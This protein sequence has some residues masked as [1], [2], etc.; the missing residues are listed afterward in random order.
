MGCALPLTG[1]LCSIKTAQIIIGNRLKII[2]GTDGMRCLR[3]TQRIIKD[4][5]QPS[6]S[7]FTLLPSGK[8]CIQCCTTR[9]QRLRDSSVHPLEC[10]INNSL[11]Y[12]NDLSYINSFIFFL[13][14][15]LRAYSATLHCKINLVLCTHLIKIF[16]I[17]NNLILLKKKCIDCRRAH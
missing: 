5:I 1:R 6:H 16:L 14:V 8:K 12:F 2:S 13:S 10:A 11:V 3:R 4:N 15:A 7:M 9:L 17:P